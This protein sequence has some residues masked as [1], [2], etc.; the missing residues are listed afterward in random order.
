MRS[1]L[2]AGSVTHTRL[3]PAPHHFRYRVYYGL[4]DLDEL[5]ALDERLT[6]FSFDRRNVFSLRTSD[7]GAGD[8][9]DLRTWVEAQLDRAGIDLEGGR[10]QL[11]AFPRVLGYVFNPISIW[12][13]FHRNGALRAVLHEVRNTFGDKHTYLVPIDGPDPGHEFDKELHVSPFMDMHSRYRFNLTVP[14]DR[15]T[16]SIHQEDASG[17]L[18]RAGLAGSRLA[19]TDRNL[20]RLFM[21]HPLVTLKAITAIHWQALRLWVKRVPFHRRPQPN[22]ES[23]SVVDPVREPIS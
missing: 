9:T 13:C 22:P 14:G 18:F 19:F 12:Y 20:L 21:T 8:G 2:Y 1:A 5:A 3:R 11:L 17:P 23:V 16:V 4:F 6:L 15:M 7:H 10:I